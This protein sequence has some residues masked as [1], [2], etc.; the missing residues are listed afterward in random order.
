MQ[1]IRTRCRNLTFVHNLSVDM[2]VQMC[3]HFAQ[4][5][6]LEALNS[7]QGAVVAVGTTVTTVVARCQTQLLVLVQHRD[8]TLQRKCVDCLNE[9]LLF[10]I[11]SKSSSSLTN[12]SSLVGKHFFVLDVDSCRR[13]LR[14]RIAVF[15]ERYLST[16]GT[17]SVQ[18]WNHIQVYRSGKTQRN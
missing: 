15:L 16:S 8:M 3:C 7:A 2:G 5:G 12:L 17:Q 6:G 13:D 10:C 18:H 14:N 1:P 11:Q 9:I 4:R